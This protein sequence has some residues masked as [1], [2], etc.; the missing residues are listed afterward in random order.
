MMPGKMAIERERHSTVDSTRRNDRMYDLIVIAAILLFAI[1]IRSYRLG[2]PAKMYFDE[3]YYAK[4]AQQ[5]LE[6][7][8]DPNWV[9]PPL[10]KIIIAGGILIHRGL[11][12]FFTHLG[13]M[14]PMSTAASW[15]MAS[16][17]AGCLMIPLIYFFALRIFRKRYTAT[18]AA[19]LL[20]IEFLH[21][22][23]S[24]IAMIDIFL[25][26]FSLAGAYAAYCYIDAD[27]QEGKYLIFSAILFGIAAA[28][29][30]NGIFPAF[31][32][33]VAM[34]F[35][36]NTEDEAVL[37]IEGRAQS[38]G[39]ARIMKMLAGSLK[40]LKV[41]LP[42]ALR[43][44][45]IMFLI[46]FACQALSFTYFF[47]IGGTPAKLFDNFSRTLHFHY[48][49]PWKHPYL[50]QMWQ[51]PLMV[52][53][54]WYL[55]EEALG[56]VFGIIAMGSPLFWWGFLIFL[57]ELVI[58]AFNERKKEHIFLLLGYFTPYIFWLISNK[59]GFFYYMT[60]CVAWMCLITAHG[61]D[62]WRDSFSGRIMGWI[63][64]TALV[65]FFV[66]F[67][68]ILAGFPVPRFFFN[69]LM[70]TRSWI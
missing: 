14:K 40:V 8:E 58:M 66:I 55:F 29:K 17:I 67:Y 23:E 38:R 44:A 54:I 52:R 20:S 60:P 45:A 46:G 48:K 36:K 56:N 15:R 4:A 19:F 34:V 22:A 57:I 5:Y 18:V 11:T 65:L 27:E 2:F 33:Y 43:I 28:C 50:S 12:G 3:I 32:C 26:L 10:G 13:I 9:H 37:L 49:E 42:R 70:W 53:P 51:W 68:P 7:K 64:L 35:L 30:W 63:Y 62:R 47:L 24:R 6:L 61:L 31:G 41:K 69:K 1:F 21:I 16:L 25:S 39:A 59:G